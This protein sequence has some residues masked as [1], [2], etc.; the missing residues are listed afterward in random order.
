MLVCK[1]KPDSLPPLKAL[2]LEPADQ[3]SLTRGD[4]GRSRQLSGTAVP[5]RQA[6][7]GG[8]ALAGTN[9]RSQ[10]HSMGQFTTSSKFGPGAERFETGG[11][12]SVSLGGAPVPFRNPPM[13][14]IPSGPGGSRPSHRTRSKRGEKRTDPTKVGPTGPQAH[15]PVYGQPHA[16]FSPPAFEHVAPLLMSENRW[17]RKALVSNDPDAPE[18]VDRKVKGLLNKLTMEKF[19]SISDQIIQWANRSENQKDGRTLIQVIRLVFEKATDEATWSEM[20]ARLCRKMME[21]ISTKVHDE[22]TKNAKGKPIAGGQLFRKYLLNKC[23]EDFERGWVAK[24]ASAIKD[25][26]ERNGSDEF[27]LYSEEYYVAQKAR[28]QGL[29][30]IKFIGELFKLQMLT[31]RIMH[32]CIKK[33]LSNA[34]NPEEEEI[35]SL[36]TLMTTVGLLL[37]TQ[38]ARVHMDLYFQRMK[39]LAQN[40][41][42]SPGMQFMLQD[43]LELRER[44]WVAP[45]TTAGP[46]VVA[47][48]HEVAAKEK[49]VQETQRVRMSRGGTRRGG[50]QEHYPQADGCT[51]NTM[52]ASTPAG[53][54]SQIGR[55]S[56]AARKKV[57]RG[58]ISRTNSSSNMFSMLE[59]SRENKALE[60]PQTRKLMLQPRT[61]PLEEP[62]HPEESVTPS[63]EDAS[64]LGEINE[65]AADAKIKEDVKEFFNV[66]NLDEAEVYFTTLPPQHHQSLVNQLTSSAVESKEPDAKLVADLFTR[67]KNK[68]LCSPEA[69]EE[70]LTPTAEII[71]D[72]AI[73]APKA[74]TLFATMVNG[75]E[76]D[77][78]HRTR[79]A[80]KSTDSDKL[81]DL[82][83]S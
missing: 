24:G 53:Y 23:Q 49:A 27:V 26:N 68:G 9:L 41:N 50:N 31:E 67:A 64:A 55:I 69:F 32:E 17:D 82:L 79:L 7:I 83:S 57:K 25:A 59:A 4:S 2:G 30:L 1:E 81:L 34:H 36:C 47:R 39:E 38:R 54:L 37:D 40:L 63:E 6:S 52:G 65:E 80:S 3:L 35:E 70:G 5:S 73:D 15:G 58:S 46:T 8:G 72:I 74:W 66:R 12:R 33:L 10:H 16:G 61:K 45:N 22:G 48:I 60:Q 29:G 21:Q 18:V 77:E 14:R 11:G 42:V 51:V 20:Y 28:R 78:E 71:E 19:D 13:Q 44:K 75:A 76:L 56:K 62:T 43:V